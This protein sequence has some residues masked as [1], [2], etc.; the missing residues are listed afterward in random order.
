MQHQNKTELLQQQ[1]T[2]AETFF[3]LE[4]NRTINHFELEQQETLWKWLRWNE[5]GVKDGEYS[6]QS[7]WM[8]SNLICFGVFFQQSLSRLV[9]LQIMEV[10]LQ[11]HRLHCWSH[12]SMLH[13]C[14]HTFQWVF[15]ILFWRSRSW[16]LHIVSSYVTTPKTIYKNRHQTLFWP[17]S[18]FSV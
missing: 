4:H 10:F 13:L 1:R 12:K 7:Q 17:R 15:P 3:F 5:T 16:R 6:Q 14:L 8:Y 18:C 11:K 2:Q 9:D